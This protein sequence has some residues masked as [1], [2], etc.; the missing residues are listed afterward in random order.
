MDLPDS[1]V[2]TMIAE[3]AWALHHACYGNDEDGNP[4]PRA[5][6]GYQTFQRYFDLDAELVVCAALG[7][8]H[9]GGL[10][11]LVGIQYERRG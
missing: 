7:I 4:I 6:S 8:D 10:E 11:G 3:G 9:G 5:A 2:Q 1:V